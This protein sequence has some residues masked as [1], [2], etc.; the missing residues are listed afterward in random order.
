MDFKEILRKISF[1]LKQK[2]NDKNLI[3]DEELY[4]DEMQLMVNK[5][6]FILF[7]I[8]F[9]IKIIIL[10]QLVLKQ[11]KKMQKKQIMERCLLKNMEIN[12]INEYFELNHIL[13]MRTQNNHLI[14][15]SLIIFIYMYIKKPFIQ[16]YWTCIFG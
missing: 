9:Q 3:K 12:F 1:P 2:E 10:F 4:I 11:E 15:I 8:S 16:D 14:N 5:I 13:Y 7:Y 6:F